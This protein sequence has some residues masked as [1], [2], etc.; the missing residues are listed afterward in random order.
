MHDWNNVNLKRH[1]RQFPKD[2]HKKQIFVLNWSQ[3]ENLLIYELIVN[4]IGV[5]IVCIKIHDMNKIICSGQIYTSENEKV[6]KGQNIC[7]LSKWS[8]FLTTRA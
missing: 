8:F 7:L 3:G 6:S 2:K 4:V 5:R 1:V